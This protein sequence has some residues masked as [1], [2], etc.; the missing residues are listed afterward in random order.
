M[1]KTELERVI[2]D[3]NKIQGLF[4]RKTKLPGTK[5]RESKG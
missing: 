4:C 3:R 5:L 1:L 2:Y